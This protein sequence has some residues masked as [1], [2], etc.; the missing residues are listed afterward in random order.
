MGQTHLCR[1]DGCRLEVIA[2]LVR[3]KIFV[4]DI[5]ILHSPDKVEAGGFGV[6]VLHPAS[7]LQSLL[8]ISI[9]CRDDENFAAW[10]YAHSLLPLFHV[11]DVQLNWT[12]DG[13]V[14]GKE[15]VE[16][17]RVDGPRFD[18]CRAL[19][20]SFL[21]LFLPPLSQSALLLVETGGLVLGLLGPLGSHF[22]GNLSD[23]FLP[24]KLRPRPGFLV[25]NFLFDRL[26][27]LF[28]PLSNG[29]RICLPLRVFL[30]DLLLALF[31]EVQLAKRRD[32]RL[33]HQLPSLCSLD[34]G[35]HGVPSV[36]LLSRGV[37]GDSVGRL[38]VRCAALA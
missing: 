28:L 16:S 4:R 37:I 22:L 11:C 14:T 1:N 25:G 15:I 23:S 8:D 17:A 6:F 31:I 13:H 21:L 24:V 3:L 34:H 18:W 32:S 30:E 9:V 35:S 38:D 2:D 12:R 36:R 29:L 7:P 10:L 33:L 5:D 19:Q 20:G 26:Q 27:L